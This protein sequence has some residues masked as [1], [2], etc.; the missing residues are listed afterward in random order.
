VMPGSSSA[1][2]HSHDPLEF[3]VVIPTLN[4]AKAIGLVLDEVLSIGVPKERVIVVDGYST[5]GTREIAFSKGVKVVLQEGRGKAAAI[6]T[7]LRYVETPIV[8]FMDG[9]FTYPAKY[10]PA[11]VEKIREGFDLVLGTRKILEEGAQSA[12]YRFGNWVLTKVFNLLFATS[13]SDVLTGMYAV[14]TDILREMLFESKGFGIETEIV[15]HVASTGGSIAEMP[16]EYRRRVGEKK[17]RVRHGFSILTSIVRLSLRYNPLFFILLL[18]ALLLIPGLGLGAFV[19]YHYFF[20]GVSYF[21]KGLTA[22]LLTVAGLQL[23]VAAAIVLYLKRL[24]IRLLKTLRQ[25]RSGNVSEG[26]RE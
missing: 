24:E 3:A 13:L 8:V 20:R 9:D 1:E 12:V 7:A 10:I 19:A 5:D 2:Q 22:V 14:R 18:G 23:L 17:L 21:V 26:L 6:R 15:A 11:L 25:N 16:I 4:E